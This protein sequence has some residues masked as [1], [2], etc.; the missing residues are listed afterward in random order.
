MSRSGLKAMSLIVSLLVIQP[1][2]AQEYPTRYVRVVTAG[3]GGG[4]DFAARLVAQGLSDSLGQNAIVDN[5]PTGLLPGIAVASAAP[6]GYTL[7]VIGSALW[8]SPF[9]QKAPYDPVKDFAPITLITTAPNVLVVHPSV[10]VQ[11]LSALIALAKSK[12]GTLNFAAGATGGSTHLSAELFKSM[13]GVNIVRVSY[14]SGAQETTDLIGGHVQL[15]FAI[16][17]IVMPHVKSGQL[18]ALA[19]TS[20]KRSALAPELPPIADSVPGYES[21][22]TTGVLAPARTPV[23][24]INRLNRDIVQFINR[25]DTKQRLL[26]AGV[27]AMGTSPDE[28]EKSIQADMRKFGKLIKDAGISSE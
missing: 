1:A 28:F 22:T 15:S 25:Q 14:K 12:P 6:D 21:T 10:P 19:V 20:A 8:I 2:H 13:T 27:E 11:S 3:I 17:A 9:L 4:S 16:A 23:E 26:N 7:L 24:I 5:R 18:R